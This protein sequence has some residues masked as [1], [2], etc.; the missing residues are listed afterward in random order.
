MRWLGKRSGSQMM[1]A[2]LPEQTV[3]LS[4]RIYQVTEWK[5]P[6]TIEV[7]REMV[8]RRLR[9]EVYPWTVS[10][11]DSGL[12]QA[13]Q[14]GAQVEVVK[15]S[16]RYGVTVS[17]FPEV[18]LCGN[19]RRIGKSM[20][21][22]CRCGQKEWTQLH[23]L[24]VHECGRVTQ[25]WIKRCEAHDDVRLDS[26]KSAKAADI[27]FT[28]PECHQ[29]VQ[30]GLGFNRRCQCGD[31]FVRWNVHKARMVYTPRSMVLINPPDPERM[32]E[33]N[34]NGGGRQALVWVVEGLAVPS[35]ADVDAP[36][37][38]ER[39]LEK[40]LAMKIPR[41]M[42]EAAVA[43]RQV[44]SEH[45]V[46]RLAADRREGA[47]QEAVDIA[48][49]LAEGH[50][51]AA[52]LA[53]E[54]SAGTLSHRYRTRYPAALERAR[55]AGLDLVDKFPVLQAAYGYTRGE[56]DVTRCTLVP[57]REA[58]KY[59]LYGY[60][61]DTEAFLVRLD[62]V[63][64]ADWLLGR[65]HPLPGWT[66]GDTD[67]QAARLAILAEAH[68][69]HRQDKPAPT[70]G[71]DLL[72]LVHTYAHRFIRQAAV[73]CGIDRDALSEYLLPGHLAFFVYAAARGDF[74]LGGMQAVFES[75]LDDLLTEFVDAE[76]R[77]PLDPGCARGS[78]AC[79]ACV[80][81]GEPSC[82]FFNRFLDRGVLF[83]RG[84]YLRR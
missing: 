11:K 9:N 46:D 39:A 59:R 56:D 80:H 14:R 54:R 69:P 4:R 51:P 21:L 13:L 68:I 23:Y 70:A 55:I 27:R 28:C 5:A 33:L 48:M 12:G 58:G 84:G 16:D 36:E 25:P 72:K 31:G 65:G 53:D 63:R 67:P 17:R 30:Q 37:T 82:R 40:L 64:V 22:R 10:D 42:A 6:E 45:P 74:V 8:R 52:G 18:W 24:G 57:F 35:P 32:A 43:A 29:L 78:G 66:S 81:L 44:A 83:G 77:C 2:F 26:P 76:H 61:S 62:P 79:S 50:R 3:D 71:S 49:A 75:N 38:A 41:E 1:R 19:C 20:D 34:R 73:L 47:E 7:D 60:R 15:V